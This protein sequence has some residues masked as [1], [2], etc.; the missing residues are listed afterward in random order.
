VTELRTLLDAAADVVPT[1]GINRAERAVA[2]ARR[3][4]RTRVVAVVVAA[5]AA[6]LAGS[7]VVPMASRL[8]TIE[9]AGP[10]ETGVPDQIYPVPLHAPSVREGAALGQ[11]AAYLL[12]AERRW[13]VR[14]VLL[15]DGGGGCVHGPIR[16]R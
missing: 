8:G 12:G 3:V 2:T 6:V 5:V 10:G 9:P 7:V 15:S 11:P 4:R 14:G 1:Y 13:L 16:V